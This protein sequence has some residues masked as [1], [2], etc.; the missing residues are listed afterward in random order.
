M[1]LNEK[2]T[3]KNI[4]NNLNITSLSRL[5]NMADIKCRADTDQLKFLDTA[6]EI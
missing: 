6:V 1:A 3:L 5:E 4:R 2:N